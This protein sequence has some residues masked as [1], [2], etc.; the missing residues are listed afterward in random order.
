M[1]QTLRCTLVFV[2]L[3]A[4]LTFLVSPFQALAAE[5]Q[6]EPPEAAEL[7]PDERFEAEY[8][9]LKSMVEFIQIAHLNPLDKEELMQKAL[10]AVFQSLDPWSEYLTPDEYTRFEST[11]NGT[12]GGI[13]VTVEIR[14]GHLTVV[15]PIAG[16]PAARA[17]IQPDDRIVAVDGVSIEGM[18]A[19]ESARRIQGEPGTQVRLTVERG[20]NRF[21]ITL[22][23]ELIKLQNVT[24]A[25]LD[26]G[27]VAHVQVSQFSA[28]VSSQIIDAINRA[29][30]A[31]TLD[32]VILD[33]RYNPGGLLNEAIDTLSQFVPDDGGPAVIVE[34]R[35][36]RLEFRK[37]ARLIGGAPFKLVVLVNG[38]SASA[39]ELVAGAIQDAKAGIIL[40]TTTYGKGTVQDVYP[41]KIGGAIKLT[42]ARYLTPSGRSV[43][44]SGVAPDVT[45]D[46][47][48]VAHQPI[49]TQRVM[50]SGMVGL[51]V[52]SL[53]QTLE[54][55][56]YD[57]GL[58]DGVFDSATAAAVANLQVT[59][60]LDNTGAV[61]D[62]LVVALNS[63]LADYDRRASM[64]DVQLEAALAAIR[65]AR[66]S[67]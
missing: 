1:R 30:M 62:D 6:E 32:G 8:D 19:D 13:G 4:L 47:Q 21:E 28:G 7:T 50:M 48:P 12:F 34:T 45:L 23:R 51:D 36:E 24:V 35:T 3:M 41:L 53:E 18:T 43:D 17:G 49:V 15:A 26:E 63:D 37:T 20:S 5:P 58:V 44:G 65:D 67:K 59:R 11:I 64:V 22:I 52:L 25:M 55:L 27:R 38:A 14:N 66:S 61:D 29:M 39:S 16:T 56:G 33:L 54:L 2:T 42:I 9:L 31:G 60:N 46:W 40:G 57:P 10:K